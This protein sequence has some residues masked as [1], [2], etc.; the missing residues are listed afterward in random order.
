VA[1]MTYASGVT[2]RLQLLNASLLSENMQA[3]SG[4]LETSPSLQHRRWGYERA[5]EVLAKL[6]RSP[7]QALPAALLW[8]GA[9][10][11]AQA[12]ASGGARGCL[13]RALLVMAEAAAGSS[14]EIRCP[15]SAPGP[16]ALV[17]RERHLAEALMCGMQAGYAGQAAGAVPGHSAAGACCQPGR[18]AGP[19]RPAACAGRSQMH[20]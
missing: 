16:F 19:G 11:A 12:P 10:A 17:G 8:Q 2:A 20:S 18:A 7:G 9:P 3:A 15:S 6:Y 4:C 14:P 1:E 5:A 13:A